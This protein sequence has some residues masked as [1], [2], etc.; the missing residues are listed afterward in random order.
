MF[1]LIL[2]NFA[3]HVQLDASETAQLKIVLQQKTVKKHDFL[4]SQGKICRHIYFVNKGC[5][6]TYYTDR[7]GLQYNI[8]FC[9]ENWWAVD[10]A[11]FSRQQPAFYAIAALEDT[12]VLYI[13]FTELEKLYTNIPKLERFFRILTQN[14]FNLYQHR[15]TS[16]LS[17]TAEERYRMFQKQYPGLE[18]RI[19]QKQVAAYLGI[20]TVFLSRLRKRN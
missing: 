8:S 7:E 2:A 15:I 13:S 3:R 12:D 17:K 9:P 10:I 5:L 16:G 11:S 14:G 4:L 19:T 20:T 6:R 18:Q 1:E